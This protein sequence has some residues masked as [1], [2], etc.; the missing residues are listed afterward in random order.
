MF[1][2]YQINTTIKILNRENIM[3]I[4]CNITQNEFIETALAV[5]NVF[6]G[7][8][9]T[10]PLTTTPEQIHSFEVIQS[11]LLNANLIALIF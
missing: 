4:V 3:C 7:E 11:M 5:E 6:D 9:M 10:I 1:F 8:Y 2:N